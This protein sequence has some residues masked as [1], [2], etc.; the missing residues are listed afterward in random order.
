MYLDYISNVQNTMRN[1]PMKMDTRFEQILHLR[2]YWNY[3]YMTRCL[4]SL[5]EEEIQGKTTMLITAHFLEWLEEKK[6]S[7]PW[8]YQVLL[9]MTGNW[10]FHTLQARMKN[11]TLP[12]QNTLARFFFFFLVALHD[13]LYLSCLIRDWTFVPAVKALSL[14]HGT[15]GEF[16][17]NFSF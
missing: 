13:L 14:N 17:C 8:W 16:R 15:A 11:C 5:I 4:L 2:R 3:K 1:K 6:N 7:K 12:L 9:L 10:N